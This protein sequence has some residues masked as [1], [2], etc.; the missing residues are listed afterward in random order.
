MKILTA[1]QI[2]KLDAYTIASEPIK[3]IDLMERASCAFVE[4]F[5]KMYNQNVAIL[6]IAGAGNNGGD[7]LAIARLLHEKSFRIKV[8]LAL[9]DSKGSPDYQINLSR[10]QSNIKVID[11]IETDFDSEVIIDGLVGSGLTRPIEGVFG[12]LVAVLNK[13]ERDIIS[14]DVASGLVS[15]KI[16]KE[17][18]IIKPAFTISFQLPKLCYPKIF[19]SLGSGMLSI[20]VLIKILSQLNSLLIII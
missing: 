4:W 14:I 5:G 18:Y 7:A 3:S 19:L 12:E 8:F 13:L 20:S 17:E 2:R 1:H 6:I 15:D 11:N 16:A 9:P 10:L